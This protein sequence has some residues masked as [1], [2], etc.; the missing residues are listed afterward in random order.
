[1]YIVQFNGVEYI[2]ETFSQAVNT[3]RKSVGQGGVATIFDDEGEQ[4]ASFYP[5]EETK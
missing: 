4:V 5:M 3:A 1:M 2:C